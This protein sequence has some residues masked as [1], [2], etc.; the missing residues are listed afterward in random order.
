[1][2]TSQTEMSTN[3]KAAFFDSATQYY[4]AARFAAHAYLTPVCANLFHHA[5]E[6]YLKGYL[7]DKL[8][9]SELKKLGHRLQDIWTRF[10]D[11]VS[12]SALD[13]F[14]STISDLDKFESIR[15]PERTLSEGMRVS[16]SFKKPQS[17]L[18]SSPQSVP[19]YE[20]VVDEMDKLVRII[21]GKSSVNPDFFTISLSKEGKK[22][23]QWDNQ[24]FSP[25]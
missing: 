8:S 7:S 14:D 6:N 16:I 13:T 9:L 23:F 18:A 10:K 12:D 17:K 2:S 5:I 25:E 15:Y 22:Y 11:D 20:L 21:F 4:V 3:Q 19:I 24:A 1:M